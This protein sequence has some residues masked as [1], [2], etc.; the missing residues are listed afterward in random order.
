MKIKMPPIVF[1][2]LAVA[3]GLFA[4]TKPNK[5]A[6]VCNSTIG[7]GISCGEEIFNKEPNVSI[8]EDKKLGANEIIKGDY[9]KAVEFLNRA[10][11]NKKDPETLIMLEN[12]KL[13][14]QNLPIK[15]IALTIPG[16]QSTPLDIPTGMLKAVGY[17][18]QQWNADPNHQWKLQVVLVDDKND[19][20]FAPGLADNLL[21]RGILAGIGSYSSAVT[22]AVKDIYQHHQTVLISSTSTATTLTNS[23]SDTFFFRVCSNNKVSGKQIADYLKANKYTKIALFHT[24]G[25]PFSDSMT[26]ALKENIP[27]INIVKDFDFRGEG[28]AIDRIKAA[29]QA[30]A[31]VIVLI[32]DAYTS[33]DPERARLLSIIKE[34]NGALP[35]IGN[36]VVKDQTLF[37]Y[38]KQQLEK[39]VISLPWHPS[40]QQSSTIELPSF[41]GDRNQ[42]DHRLAMTYDAAQVLIKALDIVP[43]SQNVTDGRHQ[44]QKSLSSPTVGINGITGAIS[45]I[46]SER[47]QAT[48]SLVRPNCDVSTCKGFRS[49]SSN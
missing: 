22:L 4:I 34:N 38:S 24:P 37:N 12:A 47:S 42:L 25:K 31:Q 39:I 15:S 28:L 30:G 40:I 27:G 1:I 18:Q 41:W 45:F 23:S 35:I 49:I 20:T 6:D 33:A 5:L 44:I 17:A 29:Q 19:K 26:A 36:E 7:D 43:L 13:P 32:P 21:K 14:I 11:A 48:N 2:G 10:W 3:I 9:N 16:S 8:Q 46:G